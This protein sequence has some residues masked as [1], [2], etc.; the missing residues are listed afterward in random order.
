MKNRLII[1]L[2]I[3]LFSLFGFSQQADSLKAL[4][5]KEYR[6]VVQSMSIKPVVGFE[7]TFAYQYSKHLGLGFS[8]RYGLA[9]EIIISH[10]AFIR[11][12]GNYEI[13]IEDYTIFSTSEIK[14]NVSL[15]GFSLFYRNYFSKNVFI[16]AGM[17]TS[18]GYSSIATTTIADFTRVLGG[19]VSIYYG[20]AKIKF[21]HEIQINTADVQ[22][23]SQ[24]NKCS[25]VI[26]FVPLVFIFN[27]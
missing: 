26:L 21:G 18:L 23:Y 19:Y 22:F 27:L 3:W 20:F 25:P 24:V 11:Q 1:I 16:N 15:L 7:Y 14:T 4:N 12:K 8:I 17:V 13:Y 9:A 6:K 5:N 2:P 10:P